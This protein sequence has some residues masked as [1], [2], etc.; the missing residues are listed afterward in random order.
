MYNKALLKKPEYLF[1]SKADLLD[2]KELKKRLTVLKKLN[3]KVM[4]ISIA[5][6]ESIKKVQKVLNGIKRRG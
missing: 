6:D 2:E 5:D 3:P 1:L 4:A